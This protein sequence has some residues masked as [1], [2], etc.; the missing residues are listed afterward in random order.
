MLVR[1]DRLSKS[2]SKYL[3]DRIERQPLIEVRLQTHIT[4]LQSRDGALTGV[5]FADADGKTESE[6]V[7]GVFLCIGGLSAHGLVRTRARPD[8]RAATS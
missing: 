8:R 7:D 3:I 4:E 2:M 6:K 1:G 5:T